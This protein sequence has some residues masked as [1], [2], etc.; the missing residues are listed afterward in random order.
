MRFS[1]RESI[2][3]LIRNVSIAVSISML[4]IQPSTHAEPIPKGWQASNV[5]VLHY[6]GLAAAARLMP[7]VR[8]R[9]GSNDMPTLLDWNALT[10]K[11]GVYVGQYDDC[12]TMQAAFLHIVSEAS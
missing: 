4:F 10:H 8:S 7:S 2:Q 12:P 11:L 6:T 1:V 9:I 3:V 5:K